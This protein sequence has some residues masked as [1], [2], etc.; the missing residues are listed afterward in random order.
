MVVSMEAKT[1]TVSA[2]AV[3]MAMAAKVAK[4]T[5]MRAIP[6]FCS[7]VGRSELKAAVLTIKMMDE[8]NSEA[9]DQD[10]APGGREKDEDQ[11]ARWQ[12]VRMD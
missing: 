1:V 11:E 2:V 6:G 12:E 8:L 9:K 7:L 4:A 3:E 5:A 10:E